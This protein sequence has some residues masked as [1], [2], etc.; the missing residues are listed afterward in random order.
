MDDNNGVFSLA[1]DLGVNDDMFQVWRDSGHIGF[2]QMCFRILVE[3]MYDLVC[4]DP[5]TI[6]SASVFFYGTPVEPDEDR[7]PYSTEPDPSTGSF[8]KFYA[9]V[10]GNYDGT[11]PPLVVKYRNQQVA[12][13]EIDALRNLYTVMATI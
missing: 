3:A 8:Y 10:L 11:L 1:Y 9:R 2:V 12:Q 4:G 13:K 7:E 5:D 6:L